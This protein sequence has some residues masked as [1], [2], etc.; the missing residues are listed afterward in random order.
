MEDFSC[1][2]STSY[3]SYEEKYYVFNA[4]CF[5]FLCCFCFHDFVDLCQINFS[6]S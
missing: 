1:Y 6:A 4:H 2:R 3:P 5:F